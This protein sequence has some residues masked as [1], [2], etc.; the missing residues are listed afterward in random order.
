VTIA[1]PT[2]GGW[3]VVDIVVAA[4]V[5]VAFGVVFVAWNA[6]WTAT[7]PLFTAVPAAQAIIYGVWLVPGVLVGLIVRRPGAALFAGL[8]SATVSALIASQWGL[9]T[10]LSGAIQGGGAELAFAL[11]RYRTWTLPIAMLAAL[12]AGIGAAIHDIALYWATMG[13]AFWIVF[14]ATLLVSAVLVA[15]VGSWLLVR[16]LVATGVLSAFAVGREQREI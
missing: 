12:L 5:A 3:R 1:T 9:D 16:A 4:A 14:T 8:V 11:G 13:T 15:G 7:T 2:S 10:I 6:I